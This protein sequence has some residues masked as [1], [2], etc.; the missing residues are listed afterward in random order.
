M[1]HEIGTNAGI[2][3]QAVAAE[4]GKIAFE[5][6]LKATRLTKSQALLALGWLARENK[7]SLKGDNGTIEAV[8]L[9]QERYF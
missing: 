8:V 2:V 6:L 4:S 3:W 7:V 9:Y 5:E 1:R